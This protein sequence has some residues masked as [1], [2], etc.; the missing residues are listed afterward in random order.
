MLLKTLFCTLY[1]QDTIL[2]ECSSCNFSLQDILKVILHNIA[3]S[4]VQL[5]RGQSSLD[6]SD[7]C[8]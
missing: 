6:S 2:K 3:V 1:L 5:R 4:I 7:M 8:H